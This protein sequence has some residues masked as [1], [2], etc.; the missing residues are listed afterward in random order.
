MEGGEGSVELEAGLGRLNLKQARPV[1]EMQED[2]TGP[3]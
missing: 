2:S 3:A 1:S